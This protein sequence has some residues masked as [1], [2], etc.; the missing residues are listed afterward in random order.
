MKK[1]R[2]IEEHKTNYVIVNDEGEFTATVRGSFFVGDEFPKVGDYIEYSETGVGQ[3]VIEKVEPRTSV[4][5]RKS[6]R[7]SNTQV[8]VANV[9]LIFIVMGLDTDFNLS[10]LERY[11]LLAKKSEVKAVIL[12]NKSDVVEDVEEYIN[13]VKEIAKDVYVYAISAVENTNMDVMLS[14]IN[15][16]TT[17]VLLGS[18][19]AGKSTITN[20]LLKEDKQTVKEVR[21][22]DGRGMHTTTARQLFTLPD[23][24]YLI[25]TPGMRELSM[26]DTK[27]EDENNVFVELSE[28]SKRCEYTDCDH[29]KSSG[30]AIKV[31]IEDG[32]ILDRQLK[33]FLKIKQERK[34]KEKNDVGPAWKKRKDRKKKKREK[35]FGGEE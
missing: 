25:D 18:S 15:P 21:T 19:G 20:W 5:S 35:F 3:A 24:G 7:G 4:V 23:G 28:I 29:Q 31:A 27:S 9:D 30:C 17:A 14:H 8:L 12:L 13:Q 10:R 6:S 33:S 32:E 2:V 11:L 34:D 16:E 22:D 1:A 26:T